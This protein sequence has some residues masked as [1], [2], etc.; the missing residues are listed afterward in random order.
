[1]APSSPPAVAAFLMRAVRV[2]P[3]M[4]M[5]RLSCAPRSRVVHTMGTVPPRER[6]YALLRRALALGVLAK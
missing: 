2:G 3:T 1:M 6:M 5:A 4:R